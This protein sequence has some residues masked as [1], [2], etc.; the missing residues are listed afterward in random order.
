MPTKPFAS[1]TKLVPAPADPRSVRRREDERF[2]TG[3]G[4]Y[5]DDAAVPGAL[6]AVVLRSPHAHAAIVAIDAE[7]ARNSPGV[8]AVYTGADIAGLGFMPCSLPVSG[9][10]PLIVP[11]RFPLAFDR[12]RHVGD[13]VAFVVAETVEL[14]R[15]ACELIAVDYDILPSVTGL[16][17]AADP[18]APEIWPQA[19]GNLALR[20][21]LGDER[22]VAKAFE[23]AAHVVSCR[24]VNNRIAAAA[25]EPRVALGDF[26]RASDRYRLSL[27][28]A[29]VHDIRRELA[30]VLCIAPERLDVACPDVG[31]GFGMKNVTYP[32]YALVLVAAERLGRPVR[33]LADRIEDFS[34]G[35]HAR[36]NLTTG[37]LALD[38][39]GRFLALEVETIANLGAYVSS[40][41]PGSAT[42]APTPA[43]GCRRALP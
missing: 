17:A 23:Q 39:K 11:P 15:E 42:T 18:D 9:E 3:Q 8:F 41:G 2:V 6:H 19:P 14:A 37:R 12:A 20:Y 26:D 4:H 28:G 7:A 30:A 35:V 10:T 33:W 24:L 27:S 38:A 32:E 40:L 5:L 25:L 29:S 13:P 16:A 22:A 1:E 36:D 43:M 21:R 31:G 34:G